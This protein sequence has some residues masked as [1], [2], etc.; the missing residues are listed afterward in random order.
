MHGN[1]LSAASEPELGPLVEHP[2][3]VDEPQG[4][5]RCQLGQGF[6]NGVGMALAER[7]LRETF[8]ADLCDHHIFAVVS[9][10]DLM[11]G[12]AS[13]AASLAG[14]LQLSKLVYLYDDNAI[15][16]DG[17]TALAFT[18][19]VGARFEA[20]GW[21]VIHLDNGHDAT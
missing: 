16:I 7:Y 1:S 17:P 9:D 14:H 19:D 15:T 8:G 10:G 5:Q 18:E 21:H 12:V 6:A 11:E 2:V 4:R 20:Y 13:E 3:V